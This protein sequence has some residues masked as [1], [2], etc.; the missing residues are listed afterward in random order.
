MYTA[1]GD[2]IEIS[3]GNWT[4]TSQVEIWDSPRKSTKVVQQVQYKCNWGYE[5]EGEIPIVNCDHN[6]NNFT[7]DPPVCVL[8]EGENSVFSKVCT[9]F[10][11]VHI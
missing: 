1:C 5:S 3:N 2:P 8:V 7:P 6:T 11:T 4:A 10:I 9:D